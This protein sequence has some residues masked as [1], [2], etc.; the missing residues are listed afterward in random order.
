M[1][2]KLDKHPLVGKKPRDFSI[3]ANHNKILPPL[4][5]LVA[6][7]EFFSCKTLKFD[8]SNSKNELE[9]K[10]RYDLRI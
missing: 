3:F 10:F 7:L 8:V 6:D 4:G 1:H 5:F 9:A 2:E